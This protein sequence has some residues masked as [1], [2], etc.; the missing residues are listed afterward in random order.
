MNRRELLVVVGGLTGLAAACGGSG[1]P[2]PM[3]DGGPTAD[4]RPKSCT[5]NGTVVAIAGNH[6]H[7]LI[8]TKAE[9]EAGVAQT[10]D[11]QGGATHAHEVTLTDAQLAMLKANQP[12]TVTSTPT[13]HAH[14]ITI[15]CA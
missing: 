5:M 7:D 13:G 1:D 3:I 8:I 4:A 6:G 14:T 11:I 9:I 15:T 12:V 2:E 10:Y